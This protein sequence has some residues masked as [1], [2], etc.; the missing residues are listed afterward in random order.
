MATAMYIKTVVLP[1][2]KIEVSMPELVEGQHATVFVV[3]DENITPPKRTLSDIL[4]DYPGGQL[5]KT[6]EEIDSYIRVERD[7]WE[8]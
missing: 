2:G 5:F 4:R 7:S 3:V 8:R 6:V 1:G